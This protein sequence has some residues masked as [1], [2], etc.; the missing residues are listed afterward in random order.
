[1]TAILTRRPAMIVRPDLLDADSPAGLEVFQL[2]TET[3]PSCHIYMEAQIFTPDSRHF[4]LHRSAHPHG[5]DKLDPE[6]RYLLCDVQ[7]GELTPITDETGVTGPSVAPDGKHFFYFVDETIPNGGRLM[8]KRRRIDG[9]RPETICVVDKPLPGTRFRPSLIYPLSTVSSDGQRVAISAFLGDGKTAGA[10]FGLMVFDLPTGSVRLVI[11][12]PSWCN[13]HPQYSRSLDPRKSHDIL[14]QENHANVC[15]ESG[16]FTVL[17]GGLGADIHVLRDD[18]GHFR[19]MPWGR[20]G[21][22]QCQGHQCWRGRSDWAITSTMTTR[23]HESQLIEGREVRHQD[24]DGRKT[25]GADAAR[26]DLSREFRVPPPP[27][28][29]GSEGKHDG[30]DFYHFATDIAGERLIT[31]AGPFNAAG[32]RLFLA[33]LGEPGVDPLRN[34]TFLLRPRSSW[35]KGTHLHPFLSPDGKTG[36]FNSDESGTLQAYM[37][38]NLPEV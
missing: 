36:Y 13:M 25:P 19:D 32:G 31:D 3:L 12:G 14:I 33:G 9:T 8:L 5:S 35:M 2:T 38:R 4:I 10:P 30:P 18:G 20:D 15:D 27:G 7:S 6:H 37:I 16:R 24:H 26:N 28:T 11:H 29:P 17:C 23:P 22:E 1:M 21:N 34:T